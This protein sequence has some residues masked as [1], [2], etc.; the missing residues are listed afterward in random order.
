MARKRQKKKSV[1]TGSTDSIPYSKYRIEWNDIASDSGWAS[2]KEFS[3]M[4]R[5]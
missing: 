5:R 4:L 3:R 2:D 1:H